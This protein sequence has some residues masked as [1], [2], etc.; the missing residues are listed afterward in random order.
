MPCIF[1]IFFLLLHYQ[2]RLLK[3]PFQ[4]AFFNVSHCVPGETEVLGNILTCHGKK[5]IKDISFEEAGASSMLFGEGNLD[6]PKGVAILAVDTGNLKD[7]RTVFA[8]EGQRAKPPFF[9]SLLPDVGRLTAGTSELG[10]TDGNEKLD[11]AR[12]DLLTKE[13][14]A[15]NAVH[16][17]Q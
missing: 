5:Q 13:G 7:N 10:G 16:V 11:P 4:S 2:G 14:I 1:F 12:Y 17:I 9:A 3:I 15:S 6:L 8:T